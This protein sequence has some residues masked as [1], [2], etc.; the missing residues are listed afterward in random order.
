MAEG[1]WTWNQCGSQILTL[2]H[3][4]GFGDT[5]E[6]LKYTVEDTGIIRDT[7]T[8]THTEDIELMYWILAT[9]SRATQIT[10]NHELVPYDKL[11]GGYAFFGAFRN[12]AINPLLPVFGSNTDIFEECCSYFE[13]ERQSFG[14]ASFT[15][16]ALPLV[17]IT[18]VL[19]KRSDE[20][21][22]RC[23]ILYDTSASQV[24][25]TEAL[26][27]LGELLSHRLIQAS[28]VIL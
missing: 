28:E 2:K 4:L 11:P 7:M 25:A 23:S 14:D 15:I 22:P 27:H 26:A 13:G 12:L 6:F 17:P 24:L 21:P 16:R 5:I 8:D 18:L 20:F 3:R 1:L 19:W 9:Y 10:L